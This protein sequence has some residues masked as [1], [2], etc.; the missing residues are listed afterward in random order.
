MA[1]S[2][3]RATCVAMSWRL[4]AFLVA[5]REHDG[6]DHGDQSSMPAIWKK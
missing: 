2:G 1:V 6:A 4:T 3:D 5:Q